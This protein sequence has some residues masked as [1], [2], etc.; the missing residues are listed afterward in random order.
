MREAAGIHGV[1]AGP[2]SAEVLR[3]ESQLIGISQD[4]LE[5]LR[6]M[7]EQLDP[8]V[9]AERF[10]I[11]YRQAVARNLDVLQLIGADV[12][13]PNRRHRLSVA[14]IT[15]SVTQTV[16]SPFSTVEPSTDI[17]EDELTRMVISVDAIQPFARSRVCWLRKNHIARK[18]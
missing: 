3:R 12:S 4:I 8:M 9:E 1:S 7:R 16:A 15:L 5:M 14:Y 17:A 18:T 13:L 6:K 11:E 10:E 2:G